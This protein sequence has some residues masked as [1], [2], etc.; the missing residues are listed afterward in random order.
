MSEK[1][2]DLNECEKCK[3]YKKRKCTFIPVFIFSFDYVS[4]DNPPVKATCPTEKCKFFELK[5]K[6]K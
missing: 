4:D 2:S 1:N 3:W 5:E 6:F